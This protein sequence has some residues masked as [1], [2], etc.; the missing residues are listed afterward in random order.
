MR[1]STQEPSRTSFPPCDLNS[2]ERSTVLHVCI[3]VLP[4]FLGFS[5]KIGFWRPLLLNISLCSF[6]LIIPNFYWGI[7]SWLQTHMKRMPHKP[8]AYTI[9][10]FV[11]TVA[12]V[13]KTP[14]RAPAHILQRCPEISSHHK[15]C[16]PFRHMFLVFRVTCKQI[17]I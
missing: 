3:Q 13:P 14:P 6:F 10:C 1:S 16:R 12:N 9:T 17:S 5:A 2:T 15:I 11:C 4:F 7:H 8:E